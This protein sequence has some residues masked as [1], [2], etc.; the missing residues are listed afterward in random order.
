M[1]KRISFF[2]LLTFVSVLTLS[3][4]DL[5]FSGFVRNYM[6]VQL[7]ED[8]DFTVMQNSFSLNLEY[9]LGNA[10]FL[11]SPYIDIDWEEIG[12]F[13]F[14]EL[15]ADLYFDAV[16]VR[17]GRQQII[18]GKGDGVFITDVVS[19][20]NLSEFL[21]PDFEEIRLGV[22]AIKVNYYLNNSTIELIWV[23]IFTPNIMPHTDSIWNTYGLD[24]SGSDESI[25]TTLANGE[26]FGRYSLITNFMDFE[27]IASTM[28]NDEPTMVA[29]STFKHSRLLM[30][31]GSF[32]SDLGSFILR[33]EGAFY[34]G[35][36]FQLSSSG[37]EEKNYVH[38]MAGI[39]YKR[40]GWMLSSQFIQELILNYESD[41]SDDQFNNKF[42]FLVSKNLLNE[43]LIL[44]LFSY[45]ELNDLN[46]LI[47]PKI[48]YDFGFGVELL[49]GANIF[50]GDEGTYGQYDQNDMIYTKV[51][52]SF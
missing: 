6:G 31:G 43:T 4:S 50:L 39:D 27:I 30:A 12:T 41:L 47:R 38:Y 14:R 48:S 3:S 8:F 33:G 10:A 21:L 17:I 35:K 52:Y 16:D 11:V 1:A 34:S 20:K 28:W 24:F 25:E 23:P 15:Y 51:K 7:A 18:W 26:I 5:S 36:E 42:T 2:L 13:D 22:T 9:S 44:E 49:L 29:P 45:V 32:S 46:A 40:S 19:P 37:T